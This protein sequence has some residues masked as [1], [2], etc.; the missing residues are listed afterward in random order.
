[1]NIVYL[2]GKT[3]S[4]KPGETM[5]A[6]GE[7]SRLPLPNMGIRWYPIIWLIIIAVLVA[8]IALLRRRKRER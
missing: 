4:L 8:A 5:D 1:M 3:Q 6:M 7:V 2:E